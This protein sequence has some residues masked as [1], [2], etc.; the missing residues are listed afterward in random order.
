MNWRCRCLLI[1]F[2]VK[3]FLAYDVIDIQIKQH[4]NIDYFLFLVFFFG[5]FTIEKHL[6]QVSKSIHQF[7]HP[8][9]LISSIINEPMNQHTDDGIERCKKFYTFS[10][11]SSSIGGVVQFPPVVS[12]DLYRVRFNSLS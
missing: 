2:I 1:Y 5:D 6:F 11:T 8:L 9:C 10:L 3:F 7:H 12:G 4:F